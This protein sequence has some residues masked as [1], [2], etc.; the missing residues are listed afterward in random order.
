[1]HVHSSFIPTIERE[2]LDLQDPYISVWNKE[3]L[4]ATGQIARFMYDQII[5]YTIE[6]MTKYTYLASIL[7]SY[8]FQTTSPNPDIGIDIFCLKIY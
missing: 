1:M 7:A 4:T 3:L 6:K 5:P 2:N 8:S